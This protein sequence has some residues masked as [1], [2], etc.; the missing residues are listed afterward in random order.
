MVQ[1]CALEG[2]ADEWPPALGRR[3]Q[4]IHSATVWLSEAGLATTRVA[5][6]AEG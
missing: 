6:V 4:L 3:A 1:T 5:P 2:M